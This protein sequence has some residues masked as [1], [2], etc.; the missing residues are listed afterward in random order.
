MEIQIENY[1]KKVKINNQMIRK[2]VNTTF[3]VLEYQPHLTKEVSLTFVNDKFIQQLNKRYR[4]VDSP[5]DVLAF[6]M[7]EGS[8]AEINPGLLGD[9]VI[10]VDTAERQA[11]ELGHALERE[12]AILLIHGL[13]HLVGYDHIEPSDAKLMRSKEEKILLICHTH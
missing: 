5:T 8:Y 3:D 1:Q 9:V 7:Q 2:I 6:A 13:L 10:S 4:G 12:L 11:K